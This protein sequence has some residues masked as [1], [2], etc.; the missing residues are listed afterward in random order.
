MRRRRFKKER[1][2]HLQNARDLLQTTRADA[3]HA[4]L[5]LLDLLKADSDAVGQVSVTDVHQ[6]PSHAHAAT[7]VLV[8]LS[9]RSGARALHHMPSKSHAKLATP[10]T[11]TTRV[12]RLQGLQGRQRRIS[13]SKVN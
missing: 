5:V 10:K 8:D 6:Q 13:E 2:W 4:S 12:P 3:V 9:D 1:H 11:T 7:D